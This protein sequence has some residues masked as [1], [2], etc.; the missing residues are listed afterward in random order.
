MLAVIAA[1]YH[2][3]PVSVMNTWTQSQVQMIADGI[4]RHEQRKAERNGG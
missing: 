2:M 4:L 1:E 3:D